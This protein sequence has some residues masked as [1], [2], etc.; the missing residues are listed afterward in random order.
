MVS[1]KDECQISNRLKTR[2]KTGY[3]STG[4]IHVYS[5]CLL[6]YK[7]L[8]LQLDIIY[9]YQFFIFHILGDKNVLSATCINAS[10]EP[11]PF[12]ILQDMCAFGYQVKQRQYGLDTEHTLK[13]L[14]KMAIF[15]ASSHVLV[16]KASTMR[17]HKGII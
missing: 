16:K 13:I 10:L 1:G 15:H 17:Y 3:V 6:I 11:H 5:L 9:I 12:I 14:E 7:Y 8:L 4:N 2:H